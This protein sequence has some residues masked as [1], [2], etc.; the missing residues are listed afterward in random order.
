MKRCVTGCKHFRD[1][2]L[3]TEYNSFASQSDDTDND[4]NK[5]NGDDG[6][7]NNDN[8]YDDKKGKTDYKLI[9]KYICIWEFVWLEGKWG[10]VSPF[11]TETWIFG[12]K[13]ELVSTV[14]SDVS[15]TMALCVGSTGPC[16]PREG[17]QLSGPTLCREK[18]KG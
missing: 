7:N 4:D 1:P 5:S 13:E 9:T 2:V 3:E 15:A 16:L 14:G 6:N 8:A 10:S 17:Y 18:K 11:G 12:E